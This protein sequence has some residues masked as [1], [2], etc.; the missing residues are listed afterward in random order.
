MKTN[1]RN[2]AWAIGV[3]LLAGFCL[4]GCD[5]RLDVRTVYPFQV[6]TMPIP[7]TL[8]PGEEVEIRCTLAPE[9]IVKGTRYTLRYFQYDGR[10]ALRIGRRGKS[11]TPN[12]RYAIAPGHFT[13]YYHSLSAERQ[14][15]EVV[16]EDN[17]GQSQTLAFDFNHKENKVSSEDISVQIHLFF[18]A[19]FVHNPD[20]KSICPRRIGAFVFLSTPKT[21]DHPHE[22]ENRT[23]PARAPCLCPSA[24]RVQR[25]C[26]GAQRSAV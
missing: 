12:D 20:M 2:A 25:V 11:L 1:I 4:V 5:R 19:Y 8:A 17:H 21:S 3:L 14:S 15:L 24:H 13:L 10:G 26:L 16:I 22:N 18:I 6:T 23:R 7:K 9:R